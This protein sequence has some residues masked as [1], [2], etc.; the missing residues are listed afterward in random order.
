MVAGFFIVESQW[1]WGCPWFYVVIIFF[2][3]V[4]L[5]VFNCNPCGDYF[6]IQYTHTI[7]DL[8]QQQINLIFYMYIWTCISQHL[9]IRSNICLLLIAFCT[10]VCW[11]FGNYLKPVARYQ[12]KLY[13][14]R[15]H[16]HL[17]DLWI[18]WIVMLTRIEH[19]VESKEKLSVTTRKIMV[20]VVRSVMAMTVINQ[21]F[22]YFDTNT[23]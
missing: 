5:S 21:F 15:C 7:M 19:L 10:Q 8:L 6:I 4:F 2:I 3:I 16:C 14:H 12:V 22:V 13:W 18:Y 23:Q 1:I 11:W 9:H 20:V 17:C